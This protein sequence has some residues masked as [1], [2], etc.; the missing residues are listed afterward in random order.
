MVGRVKH[1]KDWKINTKEDYDKAMEWLERAEVCADMSD[2]YQRSES[3][4]SEIKA[5]RIQVMQKAF[6]KGLIPCPYFEMKKTGVSNF[7]S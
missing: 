7:E 5:Q 3:E 6:E 1:G 2:D 4:K